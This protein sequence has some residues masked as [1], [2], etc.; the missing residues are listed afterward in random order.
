MRILANHV[1]I[2]QEVC[3]RIDRSV[4]IGHAMVFRTFF[5]PNFGVSTHRG[6]P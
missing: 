2:L 6:D 3:S 1:R 4:E 5:P